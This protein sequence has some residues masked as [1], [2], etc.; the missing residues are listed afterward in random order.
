MDVL[1][2]PQQQLQLSAQEAD[3]RPPT[4][5]LSMAVAER[6]APIAH[7]VQTLGP[8]GHRHNLG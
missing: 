6:T 2:V 3:Q 7:A 5:D 4:D 1:F 8:C